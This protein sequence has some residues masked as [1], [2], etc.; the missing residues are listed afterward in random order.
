MK[1]SRCADCRSLRCGGTGCRGMRKPEAGRTADFS[2]ALAGNPN[3]GKTT[4]FNALTGGRM[5]TGNWPGV[6]VERRDGLF[7]G[8]GFTAAICDLPGI[9]DIRSPLAEE[10]AA[11]EFIAGDECDVIINI[12]DA[13]SLER[14]LFLTLNLLSLGKGMILAVNMTDTLKKRGLSLDCRRLSA[15]LGI[16][17]IPICALSGNGLGLLTEAARREARSVSPPPARTFADDAEAYAFISSILDQCLSGEDSAKARTDRAD[18]VLCHPVLGR[19]FFILIM[20]AVFAL[21]FLLG[22]RAKSL[23][24]ALFAA[25]SELI[26]AAF[27]GGTGVFTVDLVCDGI[28]PGVGAAASFFPVLFILFFLLG[29]LEDCWYMARCAYLSDSLMQNSALSGRE[30]IVFLLGFGCTV[31]A[32]ASSRTAGSERGRR[33]L[34]LALPYISCSARLP[35]LAVF[36]SAFFGKYAWFAVIALYLLG[37]CVSLAVLRLSSGIRG[38][39]AL[40]IEMPDY[41]MPIVR[42]VFRTALRRSG[43]YVGKAGSVILAASALLWFILNFGAGAPPP[44]KKASAERSAHFSLLCSAE[45]GSDFGRLRLRLPRDSSQ[46]RSSSR[47]AP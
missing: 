19:I 6:T 29:I 1:S 2:A 43:A 45:R 13:A 20:S 28:I 10:K 44:P 41:R 17:V 36:S 39:D 11:R 25:L 42:N 37:I 22:D 46:R 33:R 27:G 21:T 5:R 34:I 8:D 26:R 47:P 18:R 14:S 35:V 40:L 15:L 31:G 32:V 30:F 23:L 24:A 16:P 4:L 3:C 12:A 7:R 38:G 9:Y